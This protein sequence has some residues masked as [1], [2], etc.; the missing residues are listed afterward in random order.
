MPRRPEPVSRRERPAK[1]ALTRAGIVATAVRVMRSE[2]L[3]RVTMRRLAAEL[4]TGPASLYVYVAN[5]TELHAEILEAM[6]GEVDLG[7]VGAAGD[8]RDRIDAVLGSY[9]RVLVENPGLARSALVARPSGANYL[10]LV[11]A[12][13]TL[14][15]EGGIP[16]AQAAWGLDLLLQNATASVV[17]H[18]GRE[19]SN[20]VGEDWDSLAEALAD[21]SPAGTPRVAA[22]GTQ[23]MSGTAQSRR[24]WAIRVL[25]DGMKHTSLPE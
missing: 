12:L 18:P 5:T 19:G 17:E 7:P 20:S 10:N 24:K 4:D 11:E 22:L 14:L 21:A 8:W 6:L 16:D 9:G 23:L 15:N 1:P 25:L 3:E 2:G 13:L